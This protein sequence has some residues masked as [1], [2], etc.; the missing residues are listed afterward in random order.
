M[1]EF[2]FIL[3][4]NTVTIEVN[5]TGMVLVSG[6]ITENLCEKTEDFSHLLIV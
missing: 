1:E 3:I 6:G 2:I 4:L 5:C